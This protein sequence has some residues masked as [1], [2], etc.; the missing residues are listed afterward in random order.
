MKYHVGI[1]L[2]G[3]ARDFIKALTC[4]ISKQFDLNNL[5][6]RIVPHITLLRPF[7]VKDEEKLVHSFEDTLSKYENPMFY[8]I[9]GFGTF[10]NEEKVIYSKIEKNK[11]IEEII[12]DLEKSFGDNI[13]YLSQKINL[14]SEKENTNLHCSIVAKGANAYFDYIKDFIKKQNFPEQVQ[15]ILRIYLLRNDFILKEHDFYLEKS[16]GRFDA[17]N[18]FV[19]RETLEMFRK[20]TNLDF[21]NGVICPLPTKFKL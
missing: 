4:E 13:N 14:P 18:P 17:I 19:F 2:N 5:E 16:L 1:R 9:N 11:Q 15:P 21:S 8:T 3:Y 20:K 6:K 10:E 7:S 12:F